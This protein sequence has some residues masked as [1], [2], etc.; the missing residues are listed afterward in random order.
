MPL[1]TQTD[2]RHGTSARIYEALYL[3]ISFGL[4]SLPFPNSFVPS[5][6]SLP[7]F[8]YL[9]Y[10]YDVFLCNEESKN[11]IED[12]LNLTCFRTFTALHWK[13]DVSK[14][15][16]LFILERVIDD[17]VIKYWCISSI[18]AISILSTRER[19]K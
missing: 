10:S 7:P 19:T 12:W 14:E 13:R 2:L 1:K 15:P 18:V 16:F 6:L 3:F 5:V 9:V 11:S 8:Y 4:P 17:F